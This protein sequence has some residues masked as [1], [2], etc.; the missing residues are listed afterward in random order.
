MTAAAAEVAPVAADRHHP[1]ARPEMSHRLCLDSADV[2][3]REDAIGQVIQG[4]MTVDMG[5][6]EP[7]LAVPE[8]AA[9]QAQ[10]TARPAVRELLLKS[11]LD[12][13][14]LGGGFTCECHSVHQKGKSQDRV[15]PTLV[16]L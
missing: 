11:G 9:P 4:T 5:L 1:G 13:L 6:A 7:S 14:V 8:P 10:V 15:E 16:H 2:D 12:E 3:G